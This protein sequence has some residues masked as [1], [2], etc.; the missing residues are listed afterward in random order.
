MCSVIRKW[1]SYIF[2]VCMFLTCCLLAPVAAFTPPP[3]S[4]LAKKAHPRLF[5]T[6]ADLPGIRDRI[7][8][9][10]KP[11]F[12]EFVAVMDKVYNDPPTQK[13]S[14]LLYFDTRN[15]AF[16]CAIDPDTIGVSHQYSRQQYCDKAV[17]RALA[18]PDDCRE[19]AHHF[20][21]W[22]KTG[23]CKMAA[24]LAYDWTYNSVHAAQRQQMAQKIV[25]LYENERGT[26]GF[27]PYNVNRHNITNQIL[28]HMHGTIFGALALWGDPH[29]PAEQGQALLDHMHEAF[30]VR[31][32]AISD[33]LY[34]PDRDGRYP[35]LVGSGNNEGLDYGYSIFTAYMY[36]I[37][38][39]SSALGQDYFQSSPFTKYVL[40]SYYYKLFPFPVNGRFYA[41]WHDTGTPMD[42]KLPLSCETQ[43]CT[44]VLPRMLRLWAQQLKRSDPT[45]AG[46]MSWMVGS[47][48]LRVPVTSYSQATGVRQYGLFNLFLGGERDVPPV[49]PEAAGLPLF[50][51]MGD[52]TVFKSSHDLSQSTYLEIDAPLWQYVG[53]HNKYV[54]SGLQM[55][56]YGTLLLKTVNTKGGSSCPRLGSNGGPAAG[57]VTGPFTDRY[58]S[59]GL[60]RL[61]STAQATPE[62]I[63]EGSASDIGDILSF[64][65]EPGVYDVFG[66]EYTKAYQRGALASAAVQQMVYLRGPEQHE[67]FVEFNHV[68]SRFETRKLL[69]TPADI[70]ALG[71]AWTPLETGQWSSTARVYSVTNTYAGS[72]GRLF[73]TS[74][75]PQQAS[76]VKI[77]G[78]GYEWVDAE[79]KSLYNG[80][81]D[82]ECRNFSG[83]YTL[84]IRT[85]EPNLITVYQPGDS[86]TMT[87]Q[88]QV[89]AVNAAEMQGVQ[90]A[91]RVV[92]FSRTP[93][94]VLA[95][96][97]YTIDTNKPTRHILI[98]L[99]PRTGYRV[100]MNGTAQAAVASQGG[101]L[102]FVD[103]GTGS[104]R[105]AVESTGAPASS[106]QG[107]LRSRP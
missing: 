29:V 97:A 11:E 25:A 21:T 15:Y 46:V 105:I 31:V 79:G 88:A 106:L 28:P 60:P 10:Y 51:R 80:S 56:K 78:P 107:T 42:T 53:G 37:A 19:T 64:D 90:I 3:E 44:A 101:V 39:A 20:A 104:R 63:V 94:R 76:F 2:L 84:Q 23:G 1:M 57:S 6:S 69:H 7:S 30:L 81:L 72:H 27:P 41:A 68:A 14:A 103:T 54:P 85:P 33:I 61:N 100:S 93:R 77:G 38:A 96:T 86:R 58:L 91:D 49:S 66:Y 22:W 71:A 73:I 40:L 59:L 24:G 35:A 32:T 36:A 13:Q 45:L 52:W 43:K 74:L 5:F 17:E 92:L 9:Y 95:S 55:A 4:P 89:L 18:I 70:E 67:F 65:T 47:S 62:L 83:Y 26:D 99:A 50:Q 48:D 12:R 8:A 82:A 34:G 16:L 75:W 102:S 98:G 87:S